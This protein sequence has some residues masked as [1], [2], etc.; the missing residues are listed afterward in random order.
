M[1]ADG[2]TEGVAVTIVVG[3]A[4]G[5]GPL[6]RLRKAS[7]TPPTTIAAM[8]ATATMSRTLKSVR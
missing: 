2:C 4:V 1:R 5:A 6:E 7:A 3:N 8:T